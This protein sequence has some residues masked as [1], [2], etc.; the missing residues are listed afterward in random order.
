M[1]K[2]VHGVDLQGPDGDLGSAG[3]AGLPG[4]PGADVSVFYRQAE[5]VT[6]DF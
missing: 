3:S 6:T 2:F 1:L 5:V 4:E